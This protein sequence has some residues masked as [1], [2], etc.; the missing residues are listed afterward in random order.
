[1]DKPGTPAG[2]AIQAF[3]SELSGRSKADIEHYRTAVLAV[4]AADLQR[5]A[6]HYLTA[7]KANTAV[8]TGAK[9]AEQTG[10]ET[11]HV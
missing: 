7:E 5:V 10:W 9:N 4:S 1:M 11:T 6:A 8:L 3:H 2:E